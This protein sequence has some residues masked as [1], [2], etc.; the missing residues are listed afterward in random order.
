L[1]HLFLMRRHGISGPFRARAEAERPFYPDHAIKDAFAIVV[2]FS[3]LLA[4]SITRDAAF[5]GRAEPTDAGYVPRPEWYLLGLFQLLKFFP[6]RWEVIGT[7]VLPGLLVSLMLALP[8]FDK[9]PERWPLRRPFAMSAA[10][11][12]T[13]M[14]IALTAFGLRDVPPSRA[15]GQVWTLRALGGRELTSELQCARCHEPNGPAENLD[16][17]RPT[18]DEG[19]IASHVKDPEMIAPDLRKPPRDLSEDEVKAVVLYVQALRTG[20]PQPNISA[21]E[22]TV[23]KLF[24]RYCLACHVIDGDGGDEGPVLT[25]IGKDRDADWLAAWIADPVSLEPDTDMP[26]FGDKL[27]QAEIRAIA[28]YLAKR[29]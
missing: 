14:I 20:Q 27:T 8:F 6:G 7:M 18:R 21:E 24:A 19:W 16:S 1:T 12:V 4:L 17:I 10:T 3:L 25:R 11:L 15:G 23:A 2:A 28:E 26:A 9:R 5:E 29:K 22:R 13:M